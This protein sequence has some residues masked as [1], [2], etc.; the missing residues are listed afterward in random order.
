MIMTNGVGIDLD[1]FRIAGEDGGARLHD[2]RA[3]E[4]A[5]MFER[6]QTVYRMLV[7]AAAAAGVGLDAVDLRVVDV[8][9]SV[10][11][12]VAV[13]LC[14]SAG[15][16]DRQVHHATEAVE[17]LPQVARLLRDGV[18]GVAAFDA[19]ILQVTGVEG[20]D[21]VAAIDATTAADLAEMGGVSRGDADQSARRAVA[22]LDPDG[23]RAKREARGKGVT[24]SHE[25]DGS[26]VAISTSP[27]DAARI[28][29]SLTAVAETACKHDPRGKAERRHDAAVALLTG[30]R[31]ACACGRDDCPVTAPAEEIAAALAKIVVHVVADAATIAGDADKAGWM[32]GFGVIDPHHVREVAARGDAILRPLDIAGLADGAAQAGNPYRPTAACDTAVRAVHGVCSEPGCERPAWK[33]DLD[34]VVEFNHEDPAAGGATCPCNLNSKCRLHHLYKTFADGWID[35]QIIDANG[36]IW[37]EVTTPTGYTVRSRARN[38]WLLPE[39]GSVPCRHG[40]PVAPGVVDDADQ[41]SR[42]RSRTKAKHAYRMQ[43]RSRRRYVTACEATARAADLDSAAPPPF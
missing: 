1:R 13:S 3:I 4:G 32:D 28:D 23:L 11:R 31:F 39:V 29:T 18:I 41:P 26:D 37:S 34:H 10:S 6:F 9:A 35:D 33:S 40:E 7:S 5:A 19:V 43:I 17:R 24:V 42:S 14:V 22:E 38:M 25:V 16:A 21:L 2:L 20:P 8:F 27:E 30:G 36:V 12:E 15:A